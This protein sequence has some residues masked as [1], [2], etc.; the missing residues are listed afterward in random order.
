[1]VLQ[2]PVGKRKNL[3]AAEKKLLAQFKCLSEIQRETL[4]SFAEF[5]TTQAP[6]DQAEATP[7]P[8]PRYTPRPE[9]E[10]VIAAIKRLN[11]TYFMLENRAALLNETSLLMTQHVM[12]GRDIREVID[13][14]ETVFA[15]FF[16]EWQAETRS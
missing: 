14:L 4:L 6:Q 5:L 12:Q 2:I 8:E 13:E 16:A 15:R 1:M 7:L 9:Q 3:T 10:S 11:A